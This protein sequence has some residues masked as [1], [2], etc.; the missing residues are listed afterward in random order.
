MS[1]VFQFDEEDDTVWV[2]SEMFWDGH[3]H[4]SDQERGAKFPEELKN[5]LINVMEANFEW[6]KRSHNQDSIRTI[7]LK[8]GWKELP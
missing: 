7:M 1:Y 8:H 2:T 5:L 4:F 6:N 3:K